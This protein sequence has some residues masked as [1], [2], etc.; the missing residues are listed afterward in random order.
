MGAPGAGK[1]RPLSFTPLV[2]FVGK[3]QEDRVREVL[4][5]SG[6]EF[7][8]PLVALFF[9]SVVQCWHLQGMIQRFDSL[10]ALVVVAP[11]TRLRRKRMLKSVWLHRV[12]RETTSEPLKALAQA[13]MGK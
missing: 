8:Q 10:H 4:C 6:D 12:E 7:L 11:I 5:V 3:V 1:P 2:D 9:V 13:D